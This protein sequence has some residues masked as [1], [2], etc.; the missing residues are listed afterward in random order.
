MCLCGQVGGCV[1]GV[2][3]SPGR[4][5]RPCRVPLS[6]IVVWLTDMPA[7]WWESCDSRVIGLEA[8]GRREKDHWVII[9]VSLQEDFVLQAAVIHQADVICYL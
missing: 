7:S 1:G 9:H 2:D 8:R 5:I 6:S 4:V 3:V